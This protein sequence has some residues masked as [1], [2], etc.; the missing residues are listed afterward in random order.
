MENSKN[1]R[2][3]SI[4]VKK[5]HGNFTGFL[6]VWTPY[7]TVSFFSFSFFFLVSTRRWGKSS[8]ANKVSLIVTTLS[9]HRRRTDNAVVDV[10]EVA[11]GTGGPPGGGPRWGGVGGPESCVANRNNSHCSFYYFF[12]SFYW[13]TVTA[14]YLLFLSSN[15]IL[16][17]IEPP[18]HSD[19]DWLGFTGGIGYFRSI[20]LS[21][22]FPR[23]RF[24]LWFPFF[25]LVFIST[26]SKLL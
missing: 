11:Q 6:S 14:V 23:R 7:W 12:S 5:K 8:V 2:K 20:S 21:S 3:K 22:S 4:N 18:L 26:D 13:R 9:A 25:F 16:F 15:P 17:L 19:E 24:H 1:A 10:D